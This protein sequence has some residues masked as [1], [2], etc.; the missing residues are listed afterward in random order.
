ME[1]N[2]GRSASPLPPHQASATA[3]R[4]MLARVGVEGGDSWVRGGQGQG[5]AVQPTYNKDAAGGN[6]TSPRPGTAAGHREAPSAR[7]SPGVL[8]ALKEAPE[9]V[10]RAV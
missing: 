4:E 5:H 1:K 9:M 8:S 7:A 10:G 3:R 6:S 2:E